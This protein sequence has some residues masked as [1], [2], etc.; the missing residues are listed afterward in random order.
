MQRSKYIVLHAKGD[1]G[2]IFN[3][4]KETVTV[5]S[6][7]LLKAIETENFKAIPTRSLAALVHQ[8]VLRTDH[9]DET[10]SVQQQII[11]RRRHHD[12]RLVLI[13]TYRCNLRCAYCYAKTAISHPCGDAPQWQ[14]SIIA[15]IKK[16]LATKKERHLT[17]AL[18]G[19]EPLLKAKLCRE[20]LQEA[21]QVMEEFNGS[22][23]R[24]L[25]TN[26][27]LHHQEVEKLLEEIDYCQVTLD[28][29][30]AEH[31][32]Q[33][34]F[35]NGD[36]SYQSVLTFLQKAV[37]KGCKT[38]IR[39]HLH[40]YTTAY[41]KRCAL[42]L[43]HDL[44]GSKHLCIY[45]SKVAAGCYSDILQC[46]YRQT[47]PSEEITPHE[48]ARDAFLSAGW[49]AEQLFLHNKGNTHTSCATR[50]GYLGTESFLVDS[51]NNIFFCPVALNNPE[52]RIGE[53]KRN[54]HRFFPLRDQLLSDVNRLKKCA[55]C[56]LLPL[57]E[58][59][60]PTKALVNH[61][62][63]HSI[64]CEKDHILA[65]IMQRFETTKI[66]V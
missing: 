58:Q 13:P 33:R 8:E 30:G 16:R 12:L 17:L 61:Q 62:S 28:G 43:R 25:T 9:S 49:P 38:T 2:Y 46:A 24:T 20:V 21:K 66:P 1:R 15:F 52:L 35:L 32:R 11:E 41:L 6:L 42:R 36:G 56:A 27:S 10:P 26:G 64:I 53:L 19:G 60:C 44:D 65:N 63:P 57:C 55:D 18:F 34:Q 23:Y 4:R 51:A 5:V 54:E 7:A 50:C 14:E 3:S 22:I 37:S 40:S 29:I 47:H 45:F 48:R 31:D 59:G 39:F